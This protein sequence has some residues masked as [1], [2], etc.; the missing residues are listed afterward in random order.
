MHYVSKTSDLRKIADILTTCGVRHAITGHVDE[1]TY[2]GAIPVVTDGD[3]FV[4]V[5][6]VPQSQV[7]LVRD[8]MTVNNP[9][10]ILQVEKRK[11]GRPKGSASMTKDRYE[12][13]Y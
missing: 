6:P 10:Q 11:T 9:G 2:H 1:Y 8:G 5:F 12:E 7:I 3:V 13:E 4:V